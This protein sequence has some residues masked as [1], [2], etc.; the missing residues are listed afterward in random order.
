MRSVAT[1]TVA[2]TAYNALAAGGGART[3]DEIASAVSSWAAESRIV[4]SETQMREAMDELVRRGRVCY[5]LA[6]YDVTDPHRRVVVKRDRTGDGWG[7][8]QVYARPVALPGMEFLED[9]I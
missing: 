6:G 1:S 9:V 4:V 7:G 3:F 5:Q 8:W 2:L